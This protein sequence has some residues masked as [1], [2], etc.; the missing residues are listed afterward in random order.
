M[1]V[2]FLKSLLLYML[3][4]KMILLVG[5]FGL[6][7]YKDFSLKVYYCSM[8]S[9]NVGDDL[10]EF[11]WSDLV[12]FELLSDSEVIV[13]IGSIL[14]DKMPN[15]SNKKIHVIGSGVGYGSIPKIDSNWNF[16]A[17]RGAVTRK[18][19]GLKIDT[20]LLDSAYLADFSKYIHKGE[21]KFG[22]GYIPHVQSLDKA[23]WELICKRADLE[24]IDPRLNVPTFVSKLSQCNNVICEAMHGAIFAD[25][26]RVPWLPVKAYS[27]INV[28]KWNDWLSAFGEKAKFQR[29]DG[30]WKNIPVAREKIF[31]NF[32]KKIVLY[33]YDL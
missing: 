21:K 17:V 7:F 18:A 6:N 10:N 27:H 23:D 29:I 31:K 14:N 25:M 33:F 30:V 20:P 26:V 32:I 5:Y 8:P 13:G 11:I 28:A 15:F 1:N 9:G 19:L 12:D 4:S 22:F 16:I 2:V 24:F 3:M